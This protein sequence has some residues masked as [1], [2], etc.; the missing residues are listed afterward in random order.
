[1]TKQQKDT[2]DSDVVG[3]ESS[4]STVGVLFS[5]D[6]NIYQSLRTAALEGPT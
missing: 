4:L 2:T 5:E 1:M 3:P 6:S